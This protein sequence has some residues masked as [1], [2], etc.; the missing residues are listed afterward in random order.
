MEKF[1]APGGAESGEKYYSPVLLPSEKAAPQKNTWSTRCL[2]VLI[3][4]VFRLLHGMVF[5]M[6][7]EKSRLF[8]I[9]RQ[10]MRAPHLW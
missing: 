1:L 4:E 7:K 10:L 6:N 3:I 9:P 8:L 5:S 2:F